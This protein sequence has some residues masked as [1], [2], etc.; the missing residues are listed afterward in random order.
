MSNYDIDLYKDLC[1]HRGQNGNCILRSGRSGNV[2]ITIS[3]DGNCRRI[4]RFLKLN[5]KQ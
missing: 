3:C 4:K 1:K 5:N 2:H